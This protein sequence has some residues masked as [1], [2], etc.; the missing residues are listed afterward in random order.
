M[1]VVPLSKKKYFVLEF[2]MNFMC[3]TIQARRQGR[4]G[5]DS[6]LPD[7]KGQNLPKTETIPFYAMIK[8]ACSYHCKITCRT[9]KIKIIRNIKKGSDFLNLIIISSIL[10]RKIIQL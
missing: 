1:S 6:P 8:T 5:E 2:K 4:R 10:S 9:I 7:L 3:Y